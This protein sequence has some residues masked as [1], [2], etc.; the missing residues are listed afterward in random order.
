MI[1]KFISGDY[2]YVGVCSNFKDIEDKVKEVK[3]L[4]DVNTVVVS[5]RTWNEIACFDD[6][7]YVVYSREL[8]EKILPGY[9]ENIE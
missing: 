3:C 2:E 7:G 9:F 8:L 4:W 1:I 6:K 5:I